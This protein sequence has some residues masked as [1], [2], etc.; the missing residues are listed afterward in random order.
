MDKNGSVRN[1]THH[2]KSTTKEQHTGI[3]LPLNK[4]N[5]RRTWESEPHLDKL[6]VRQQQQKL[7]ALF[8]LKRGGS[9]DEGTSKSSAP[10]VRID[11]RPPPVT[12]QSASSAS[13]PSK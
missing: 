2:V 5:K 3:T 9:A 10:D 4:Q 1:E 6:G 11:S 12:V 7:S 13:V 8:N